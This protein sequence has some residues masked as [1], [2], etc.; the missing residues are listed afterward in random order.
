MII[1]NTLFLYAFFLYIPNFHATSLAEQFKEAGYIE[2]YDNKHGIS[3]FDSLYTHFDELIIFLQKNLFFA[4]K[5]YSIKER[6]IRF[7]DKHYYST[8]F[9]GFYDES[10]R[11]GRNQIAFYYSIHFHEFICSYYPECNQIP[12][13]VN[14]LQICCEIQKSYENIFNEAVAELGLNSI[15]SL[16]NGHPPILFKVVKYLPSYVAQKPHYDGTAFSLLLDS[17][18]NQSLLLSPYKPLLQ[19]NDFSA[20]LRMF[21]RS[22]NQNSILLIPGAL[23]AEFSIYPTPHIVISNGKTRYATIAFAMRPHYVFQKNEFSILPSFKN[24]E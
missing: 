8:D 21:S 23:L 4:Q 15:F 16:T 22:Y 2:I 10:K 24:I 18:D 9:F 11:E 13:F 14:F 20:P 7:K 1:K 3:T 17:T 12:E 19:V 6:F 5:L